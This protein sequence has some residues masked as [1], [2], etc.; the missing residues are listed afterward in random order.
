MSDE[1]LIVDRDGI[2]VMTINRPQV[3]NAINL[4]T[5]LALRTAMAEL[6]AQ[7]D[8]RVGVLTGAGGGFS[9]GMDLKAF[10]Q[11]EIPTVTPGG[12]AGF[13]EAP[14]RKPLIAAVEGFALAGGFELVL[15]CDLVVAAEDS[16]FGLPEAS[17][18]LVAAAGGLLRLPAVLPRNVAMEM[19]LTAQPVSATRAYELGLVNRLTSRDGALAGAIALA[20]EI[21]VNAPLALAMSKRIIVESADWQSMEAF[22]R[23]RPLVTAIESSADARE[24]ALAFVEKRPPRW[25]GR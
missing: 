12:F 17:R 9:A 13:T 5:A 24:G 19:A 7:D 4:A 6:D 20:E 2:R 23:Q 1:V 10:G 21:C 16:R 8:L 25:S 14:P 18:G 15:A 11:G 3:R 22:D